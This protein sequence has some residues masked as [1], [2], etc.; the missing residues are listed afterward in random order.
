MS[1]RLKAAG[2]VLLGFGALYLTVWG[3]W[4]RFE[5]MPKRYLDNAEQKLLAGDY[6]GAVRDYEKITE[7]YSNSRIVPEAHYW[8]GVIDHL[9][10]NKPQK[11]IESFQKTIQAANAAGRDR[12]LAARKYIAEIYEKKLNKPREA[13]AE[14]E[15]I[16]QESPH[17][18]QAL[19]SQYEVGELYFNLGDLA[20][21][22]AEWDLLVKKDPKSRL[23]PAALYREGSTYFVAGNCKEALPFYQRLLS[24]YP[25]KETSHYYAKFDM[26][27]CLEEGQ[28]PAEALRLYKELEG[29]YPNKEL[30]ASKIRRLEQ[31]RPGAKEES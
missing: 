21:A 11:A 29:L 27:N 12:V 5:R 2:W 8:I 18:E 15:K 25:E 31:S 22:R 3:V 4:S 9:Y 14:Y 6:L 23:A 1:R 10:L 20:Q 13:I 30:L 17:P 26:A 16:I 24:D 19:E 28:K 7:E